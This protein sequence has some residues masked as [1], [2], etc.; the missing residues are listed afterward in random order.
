LFI[1]VIGFA[2]ITGHW[3][4]IITYNEWKELIPQA[5]QIGH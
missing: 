2:K 4:T 5:H 3:D 1:V